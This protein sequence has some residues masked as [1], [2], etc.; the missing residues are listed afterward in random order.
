MHAEPQWLNILLFPPKVKDKSGEPKVTPRLAALMKKVVELRRAGLKACNYD[1][2]CTL[3]RICPLG[4]RERPAYACPRLAD[5]S[6]QAVNLLV[7]RSSFLI[8]DS[9][10]NLV[11]I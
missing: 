1:E 8:S 5:S 3:Q 2:E 9:D 7:V 4:R 11:L 10:D 6:I